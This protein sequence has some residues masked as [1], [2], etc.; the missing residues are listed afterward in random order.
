MPKHF[1]K[2]HIHHHIVESVQ[3]LNEDTFDD[4]SDDDCDDVCDI[5]DLHTAKPMKKGLKNF[6]SG[7]VQKMQDSAKCGHYFLKSKV[8]ASYTTEIYDVTVTLSQQSGFVRD[9]SCTC[10]AS[11]MGRCSHI[12]G[13]LFALVDYIDTC[14]S[15][16]VD[17]QSC[18][19]LPCAWNQGRKS[20]KQPKKVQES[21]YPSAKKRK[22]HDIIDFDPRAPVTRGTNEEKQSGHFLSCL[23]KHNQADCMWLSLLRHHY[24]DYSFDD[25][26]ISVLTI[27]RAQLLQ[28]LRV[29]SDSN[30]PVQIVKQQGTPEWFNERRVRLTASLCKDI[31]S[32]KSD[33]AIMNFLNKHL[34]KH[35]SVCT[36]ALQYGIQNERI[37]RD[38]YKTSKN[39]DR[40]MVVETGYWV[41]SSDPEL[42]CS[43]DG[44]IMDHDEPTTYGIL[45]I[46]CPKSLENEHISDFETKLSVQQKKIF[47]LETDNE[48]KIILKRTHKYYYQIQMQMGVT[49]TKF[50][51]FVVWSNK[52]TFTIR[53]RFDEQF[54]A[55]VKAKLINFHHTYLCPE[56][57]EMRSPRNL[58][59]LKI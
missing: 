13:L 58:L 26:H 57:F 2:G 39:A 8:R 24:A 44:L 29:E 41:S 1:N 11:A 27:K 9:A 34:W 50:C 14:D 33:R 7:H 17:P 22:V 18:T 5:E 59:P 42:A 51:D 47:F 40:F 54:W 25:D 6:T 56:I 49:G 46:K 15:L 37:A 23:Q 21:V 19:S 45:E 30:Y 4:D 20:N 35:D 38:S 48:N 3:F 10:R 32:L 53:V 31:V 55:D 43:P 16:K 12:T 28:N 52:E 36:P